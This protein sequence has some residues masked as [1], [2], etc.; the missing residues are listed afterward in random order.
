MLEVKEIRKSKNSLLHRIGE[1]MIVFDSK[2][3]R[4]KKNE[5]VENR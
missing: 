5:Y 2:K 3:L 1:K 4:L